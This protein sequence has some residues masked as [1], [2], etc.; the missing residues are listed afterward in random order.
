MKK[1]TINFSVELDQNNIPD[2]I[3]W[4]ATDKPDPGVSETKSMSVA[5]WDHKHKNTL[6]IDLWT[7]DMPVNEMKRFYVDCIGGLAQSALT[8]TGDEYIASEI[9]ALCDRLVKH[10]QNLKE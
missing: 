1:S 10:L 6:R 5:L 2:K 9:N 7:K 3:L 4:D 8:A